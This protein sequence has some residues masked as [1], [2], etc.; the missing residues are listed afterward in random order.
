[1]RIFILGANGMLARAL[2]NELSDEDLFLGD[3]PDF[4]LTKFDDLEEKITAL[5]PEVIINAA[6]YTNVDGC[7]TDQNV[8]LAVNGEAVGNLAKIAKKIGSTLVHFSTDYVFDGKNQAGY[9]E[10]SATAPLNIYGRSKALGE[11]LLAENCEQFY[12]IR[13][14]WLYGVNG[15]NFVDTII[16]LSTKQ[17]VIKVVND[18]VGSPTYAKDLAQAVHQITIDKKPFGI[19]HR[20]ND[21]QCS[22]YDF[23]LEIKR[24]KNFSAEIEAITTQEMPRPATRPSNSVLINT[25]LPALRSWQEALA[26]YLSLQS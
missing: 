16:D 23:A 5:K 4:D 11:K 26:D 18:Q 1:M 13:S 12:L 24:I 25:K 6:A 14:A 15:K 21:G 7:E 10:D 19:Y 22:W 3:L 17:Q 2:I 9:K 20:T 8:C